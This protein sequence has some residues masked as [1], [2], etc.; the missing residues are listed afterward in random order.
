VAVQFRGR[1]VARKLSIVRFD[2]ALGDRE[3]EA[4]ERVGRRIDTGPVWQP[5]AIALSDYRHA[6]GRVFAE[7]M[8]EPDA[9]H[10]RDTQRR[11]SLQDRV[12]QLVQEIVWRNRSWRLPGEGRIGRDIVLEAQACK[13][14][15]NVLR[16]T[17]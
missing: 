12:E 9:E 5:H 4:L 17:S 1:R 14:R 10:E 2:F 11:A 16:A 15:T 7:K 13:E 8:F 6:R 3:V